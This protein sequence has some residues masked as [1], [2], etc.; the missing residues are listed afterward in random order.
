MAS[1][2]KTRLAERRDRLFRVVVPRMLTV[3]TFADCPTEQTEQ[4]TQLVRNADSWLVES[5]PTPQKVSA[6]HTTVE[7]ANDVA[8]RHHAI[9][10]AAGQEPEPAPPGLLGWT[11]TNPS[12]P[13]IETILIPFQ[14]WTS[15]APAERGFV[16]VHE[17][18]HAHV[19][20]LRSVIPAVADD[21]YA[22]QV[23]DE[24]RASRIAIDYV[25]PHW[26]PLS[27]EQFSIQLGK[28]RDDWAELGLLDRSKSAVQF[29]AGANLARLL[30]ICEAVGVATT[31][32]E[33]WQEFLDAVKNTYDY[34]F[35][36]N[37]RNSDSSAISAIVDARR[38][39]VQR[40]DR[41]YR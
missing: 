13:L 12:D 36:Q 23:A 4:F 9:L 6:L 17:L 35:L 28:R 41:Q 3:I 25:T 34:R 11:H 38:R 33:P 7:L 24:Y 16:V 2:G 27:A 39:L 30:P 29:Q 14:A 18:V 31:S 5:V 20:G 10:I 40:D 19:N 15:M 37:L 32:S 1:R 26:G 22:L 8:T 21:E